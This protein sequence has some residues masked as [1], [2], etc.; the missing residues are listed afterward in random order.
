MKKIKIGATFY[1]LVIVCVLNNQFLLLINCISALILHELAHL[2]VAKS[3]GYALKQIKLDMFGL[4]VDLDENISDR[5]NFAINIAGPICNLF[6]CL[7]YMS[8]YW[9]FPV[10]V[11]YLN[12]FCLAN[13]TLCLFNL[14]PIYPLDGGKIFQ[15]IVRN[16]K[17]HLILDKVVRVSLFILSIALFVWSC[18]NS[19]NFILL[20]VG[21]FFIMSEKRKTPTFSLFKHRKNKDFQRVTIL[22]ISGNET[23][24]QLLKQIK[25]KEYTIF[26]L[27]SSCQYFDEDKIIDLATHIPLTTS[28]VSVVNK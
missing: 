7:L 13:L 27:S 5:D 23:L 19:P 10:S 28:I 22:K 26:Y 21:V 16:E 18:S 25:Q 9:L 17:T 4:A 15:S 11:L 1:L 20:A 6:I 24:F 2:M 12:T 3:R 8:A 14:L